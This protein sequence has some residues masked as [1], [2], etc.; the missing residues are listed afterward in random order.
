MVTASEIVS[1]AFQWLH[2]TV[3]Q[4]KHNFPFMFLILENVEKQQNMLENL[5]NILCVDSCWSL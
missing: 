1:Q 5:P 4:E 3:E 2:L